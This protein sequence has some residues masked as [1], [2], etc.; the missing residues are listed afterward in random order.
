MISKLKKT[1]RADI[2]KSLAHFFKLCQQ[3]QANNK[4]I[5]PHFEHKQL[6]FGHTQI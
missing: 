6:R 3:Q 1:Y 2:Q 5:K 4:K